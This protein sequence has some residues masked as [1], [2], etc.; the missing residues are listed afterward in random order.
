[1]ESIQELLG[2][3]R[4][5]VQEI[6]LVQKVLIPSQPFPMELW[7]PLDFGFIKLNFD[8]SFTANTNLS[9]AA[10]IAR[11]EEGKIMGACSY[12]YSDAVDA[13]VA[14]ARAC[15]RALTFAIEMGFRKILIEGD[16]LSIIKELKKNV[17]G[18]SSHFVQR[19]ANMAAH[20]LTME[21]RQRCV[22]QFWVEEAPI[23][24]ERVV[25]ADWQAWV[26]R[27]ADG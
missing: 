10:V 16:S 18:I 14:E 3:T 5:Y 12:P 9:I 8:A 2:L 4:G 1:M 17:E 22:P 15:G 25:T 7:R 26:R 6:N 13:F 11:N 20:A 27:R 21:G 19:E 24:V 23:N